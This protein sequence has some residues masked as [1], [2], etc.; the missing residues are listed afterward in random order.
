[1]DQAELYRFEIEDRLLDM[2]VKKHVSVRW[3]P[4]SGI[5]RV[6]VMLHEYTWETRDEVLR[7]LLAFEE[8]HGEELAV[9][10]DIFPLEAATS[11]EYAHA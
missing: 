7:R 6:G 3:E 4:G 5:C 2:S 1:M 8:A 9:E 10:V 11:A